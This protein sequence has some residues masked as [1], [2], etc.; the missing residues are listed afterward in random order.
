MGDFVFVVLFFFDGLGLIGG[1]VLAWAI[2]GPRV[3][4]TVLLVAAGALLLW[5]R[6]RLAHCSSAHCGENAEFFAI[7]VGVSNTVG[8]AVGAASIVLLRRRREL[9]RG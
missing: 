3:L 8:L 4:A 7:L 2:P 6:A 5:M 9:K 1:L